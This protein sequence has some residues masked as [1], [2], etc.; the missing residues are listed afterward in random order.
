MYLSVLIS[1]YTLGENLADND[2]LN[3]AYEAWKMSIENDPENSKKR[4]WKLP[5]LHS[6]YTMEQLFFIS[7][8]QTFCSSFPMYNHIGDDHSPYKYRINGSVS[9]N[10]KFAKVF[11]CPVKSSINP[12]TKCTLCPLNNGIKALKYSNLQFQNLTSITSLGF[13]NTLSKSWNYL[14]HSYSLCE[15]TTWIA[16]ASNRITTDCPSWSPLDFF[17]ILSFSKFK[18]FFPH[19]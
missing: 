17:A 14:D 6:Q 13:Q 8:G 19:I 16:I 7:F 18:K 2:G 10:K 12:E 5:S 3:R 4:N 15:N 9:N 1:M 11:N